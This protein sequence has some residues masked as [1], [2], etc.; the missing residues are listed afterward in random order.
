M[1]PSTLSWMSLSGFVKYSRLRMLKAGNEG[2]SQDSNLHV[3]LIIAQFR[4]KCAVV[5]EILCVQPFEPQISRQSDELLDG[6]VR[7]SSGKSVLTSGN[8][9]TV[10]SCK[11][12]IGSISR[13]SFISV[14]ARAR[15][16]RR[17]IFCFDA[18][19]VYVSYPWKSGHLFKISTRPSRLSGRGSNSASRWPTGR[20]SISILYNDF[21][22]HRSNSGVRGLSWVLAQQLKNPY[23]H[24]PRLVPPFSFRWMFWSVREIDLWW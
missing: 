20:R 3:G 8:V 10:I 12:N 24:S 9:F 19:V 2:L 7:D 22:F 11:A 14:I 23:P 18:H 4:I 1:W 15:P 17:F 6:R 13:L 21:H 5:A 16:Y